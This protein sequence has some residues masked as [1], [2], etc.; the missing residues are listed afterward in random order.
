MV[1]SRLRHHGGHHGELL[2]YH[3]LK[4]FGSQALVIANSPA[5]MEL[6]LEGA[7]KLRAELPETV[8]ETLNLHEAEGTIDHPDYQAATEVFYDRHVMPRENRA[9]LPM[10]RYSGVRRI[11]TCLY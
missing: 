7:H 5:S 3:D 4:Q 2:R 10:Q 1:R 8:Q 6:W 9:T 11:R